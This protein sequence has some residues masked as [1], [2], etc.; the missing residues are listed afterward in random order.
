MQGGVPFRHNRRELRVGAAVTTTKTLGQAAEF[1]CCAWRR[2]WGVQLLFTVSLTP[3]F[4]AFLARM[5]SQDAAD[6]SLLG[7]MISIVAGLALAGALLRLRI[8]GEAS[9]S[10][11]PSGLQLGLIELRLIGIAV[12][13]AAASLLV[14]LPV[15]AV[16]ALIFVLLHG[17]APVLLHGVGEVPPSFLVAGALAAGAAVSYLYF[18]MRLTLAAPATVGRGR[19]A[20]GAGWRLSRGVEGAIVGVLLTSF[21]PTLLAACL[22]AWFGGLWGL[23]WSVEDAALAGG[24]LSAVVSFMQ[25]PFVLGGL[26]SIYLSQDARPAPPVPS[27][28]GR[29][30]QAAFDALRG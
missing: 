4:V 3:L 9:T 28:A 1:A 7:A 17:R 23:D 15:V 30:L 18:L 2:V 29:R 20:M 25:M 12:G 5:E 21:A 10:L 16:A 11:G 13:G 26:G 22:I 19:L 24:L 6:L 8:E 14:W 27:A